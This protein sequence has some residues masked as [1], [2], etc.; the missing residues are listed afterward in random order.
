MRR[1]LPVLLLVLTVISPSFA[2]LGTDYTP[3]DDPHKGV[4]KGRIVLGGNLVLCTTNQLVTG[5]FNTGTQRC[6]QIQLNWLLDGASVAKTDNVMRLRNKQYV[7]REI[8][9]NILSNEIEP[10]IDT[11]DDFIVTAIPAPLTIKNPIGT[12]GNPEPSQEFSLCLF[13]TSP[14]ALTFGNQYIG[15]TAFPLPTTTTGDDGPPDCYKFKRRASTAKWELMASTQNTATTTGVLNLPMTGIKMHTTNPLGPSV[16]GEN[17]IIWFDANSVECV[18]WETTLPPDYLGSPILRLWHVLLT[19]INTS[20][21]AAFDVKVMALKAGALIQD[22]SFGAVN[23]CDDLAIPGTAGFPDVFSCPSRITTRWWP[24]V[25][26]S[27]SSVP[28]RDAG[29]GPRIWASSARGWVCPV[30]SWSCPFLSPS[31]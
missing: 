12:G 10:D 23:M 24:M 7:P 26:S 16:A 14:R 3:G 29:V 1:L 28:T 18:V 9:L 6:E 20:H 11:G 15:R 25:P 22:N 2:Q 13:S 31:P 27:L 21:S 30:S 17:S 19:D 4:I 5:F 8:T